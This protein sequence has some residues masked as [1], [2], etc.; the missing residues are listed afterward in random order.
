[1]LSINIG[2]KWDISVNE[3]K[4]NEMTET[5]WIFLAC[6]CSVT[7]SF[8]TVPAFFFFFHFFPPYLSFP[9]KAWIHCV[10]DST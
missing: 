8:A 9:E 3:E 4:T 7:L 5:C 2:L 1:M 6:R 10:S